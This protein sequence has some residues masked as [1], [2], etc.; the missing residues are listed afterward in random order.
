[1]VLVRLCVESI[2]LSL[3]KC[4][5]ERVIDRSRS[6]AETRSG[7]AIDHERDGAR[8]HLLIGYDISEFGKLT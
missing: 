6:D 1:M 5:V 7:D 8:T 2:D 3:A 4:I